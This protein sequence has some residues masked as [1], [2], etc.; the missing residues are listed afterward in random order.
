VK[1]GALSPRWAAVP[2]KKNMSNYKNNI[3]MDVTEIGRRVLNW[4]HL[5]QDTNKYQTLMNMII[6]VKTP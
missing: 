5:T 3:M 2:D 4:I 1:R 6:N